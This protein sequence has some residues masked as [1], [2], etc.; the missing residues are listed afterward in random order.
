MNLTVKSLKEKLRNCPKDFILSGREFGLPQAEELFTAHLPG[1]TL[2]VAGARADVEKLTVKGAVSLRGPLESPVQGPF[3]A[4][5][6]FAADDAGVTVSGV[7]IDLALPDWSI[8]AGH[9]DDVDPSVLRGLGDGALHLVLGVVSHL[10]GPVCAGGLGV[11]PAFTTG[12]GASRPYVWGMRPGNP[13]LAWNLRGS[14]PPV[15]LKKLDDL[16]LLCAWMSVKPDTFSLPDTLLVTHPGLVGLQVDCVLASSSGPARILSM[17]PTVALD[18]TWALIPDVLTL[19]S[20]FATFHLHQGQSTPRATIGGTVTLAGLRMLVQVSV[21]ELRVSGYLGEKTALKPLLDAYLPEYG[22]TGL[23]SLSLDA[24]YFTADPGA[25]PASYEFGISVVGALTI[26]PAALTG[27]YLKI[28]K[29]GSG[30]S[31]TLACAWRIGTGE[32]QLQAQWATTGWCFEGILTGARPAEL[33]RTFG[34]DTPPVLKDLT[35]DRLSVRFD[36]ADAKKFSLAAE[37]QFPLGEASARLLLTTDLKQRTPA[38]SGWDQTYSGSLTLEVPQAGGGARKVT[39]TISRGQEGE[40]TA[41]WTDSQGVSLADLAKLLGAEEETAAELLRKLGTADRITIGY[42]STRRSVVFAAHAKDAGGSLV[43]ASVQPK[44]GERE[45]A[46]RASVGIGVGLSQVPLLKDQIPAEQ[47]LSLRGVGVLVASAQLPAQRVAVLN[48]ALSACD[49]D[50][51]LLPG[52]GLTKGVAFAVDVRLPGTAHPVSVRVKGGR[53]TQD[54]PPGAPAVHAAT[55]GQASGAPVVAWVDVQ[56]AVGPVRLGRVGVGYVDG[57]VWVLFEAS[58]GMAGLTL[59]VEGLGIGVPLRDPA[60]PEFRLDG[61]SAGYDRP[62]LTVMGALVNR[63]DPDYALLIE[64]VLVVS[65]SKFGLTALGAYAQPDGGGWPSM[66]LFGKVSGRFGG[67][68]PV[69]VTGILAG[70]GFNSTVRVPE[71]DRVLDFPF[72]KN[73]TSTDPDTEPLTVLKTLTDGGEKAVVRP[74]AGQMWFAAGLTF[75]V[76]EFLQ[77]QALLVLEVGD[78]FA[79]AVLGTAEARFPKRGKAY[80]R[81]SLG[82]SVKYRA[83]EGILKLTAQL[84]PGSYLIDE[85]CVLTGGFALYVWVDGA[86]SGDFVLTLGGYHPGY[87][88]PAH[89]PKVPR[90]GFSWPVTSKLTIAGGAFFA[91]TPGAIMAGGDLEVNYRSGDLHAWLTAHAR[92]LMEWAPLRYD[93]GI[94]ISVGIS[95]VLDLWLVRE[96]IRVEI[97]ATLALWGPPTAGTVTVKLWFIKVTVAFGDGR[98]AGDPIATW[99]DVA[100]QLP[101]ATDAVRLA[102]TDGLIPVTSKDGL[103]QGVWVVGPG[104]FSFTVRTAV[105][106]TTWTL[107]GPSGSQ[108][109]KLKGSDHVHL[110]PMRATDLT[111]DF[112]LTL[113]DRQETVHDLSDWYEAE[114]SSRVDST[115]PAA[116]WGRYGG[117]LTPSSPQRVDRQLTGVELRLPKPD[118]GSS[119]GK[120][121]AGA[122]SHDDRIPDGALPLGPPLPAEPVCD[123]AG[124]ALRREGTYGG[125]PAAPPPGTGGTVPSAGGETRGT[126]LLDTEPKTVWAR[127]RLFDAMTVMGVG[128]GTNDQLDPADSLVTGDIEALLKQLP[129]PPLPPGPRLFVLDDHGVLST[130]DTDSLTIAD[131]TAEGVVPAGN[132]AV[133]PN[134]QRTCS[135]NSSQHPLITRISFTP[136]TPAKTLDTTGIWVGQGVRAVAISP[137]SA[138]AFLISTTAGQLEQIAL[139]TPKKVRSTGLDNG[140]VDIVCGAKPDLWSKKSGWV[141]VAHGVRDSVVAVEVKEDALITRFERKAGPCPARLAMD[142]RGRWLYALN[143]GQSTVSVVDQ[144]TVDAR[145][146]EPVAVLMTGTDPSALAASPDGKRLY[147][148][149]RVAGTVSVF[150]VSGPTPR[151]VGVPVWVGSQ[152]Q[153][154]AVS[155]DSNRVFVARS[156]GQDTTGK[157]GSDTGL[158]CV[159]LLDTSGDAPVL[160][161]RT[162]RLSA[163]PVAIALTKAPEIHRTTSPVDTDD[164]AESSAQNERQGT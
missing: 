135:G 138:W 34:I 19:S 141:Y 90:L 25:K 70:F 33:F 40:F 117:K 107:T 1:G 123:V 105:P 134:G 100:G 142:P 64:G 17:I 5:V 130:V 29:S 49:P 97:G 18:T 53:D 99:Q 94:G 87:A 147:V 115:L 42:S 96:T 136:P 54:P 41:V 151:E 132:L 22:L 9:L 2:T 144:L 113:T 95:Y 139:K 3:P 143:A 66:F 122:L 148:T 101:A 162:L 11:E 50:L 149:N 104:A 32:V 67:P 156:T 121:D 89:Y 45:W 82:M 26:G 152:P 57:T 6:V 116:L 155:P 47:D 119:P 112:T 12:A 150:D 56:R 8:P 14:F 73:L 157:A 111:S 55:A 154:L 146:R 51:A 118:R 52:E 63:R 75:N 109:V 128:P 4:E 126:L 120:I 78:D 81:A 86:R 88:V 91:L 16:R 68:P 125:T 84:A 114:P 72:L 27:L 79:L 110:R 137:D 92:M 48:Q 46:V 23:D 161:P 59:G 160:L 7:R 106:V 85:A 24:L 93:I 39:F 76:F 140:A 124:R 108:P 103:E 158:G 21:P 44:N 69:E 127:N 10:G 36:T 31:A 83:S 102:A 58:L 38:G 71:G 77:C 20:P 28:I 74:A 13:S 145:E 37:A 80:A 43:V 62:P 164:E 35:V 131:R 15:P 30:T 98:S 129:S 60:K 65:A 133:S 153:A 159:R 61:L 163:T